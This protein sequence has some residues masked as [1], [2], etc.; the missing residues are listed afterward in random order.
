V[1]SEHLQTIEQL[2]NERILANTPVRTEILTMDQARDRGAMMIFEEKYGDVVRMLSMADSVELCGGTHVRATGDIGL[3]KILT[4]QG[5]A[6]GVRRITA[7]TGMNA[8]GYVREL[9]ATLGQVAQAAKASPGEV[10][11]KVSKLIERQRQLEKQVD[12]L[13]RKW[14][15]GGGT[16]GTDVL[17]GA[18]DI[19]GARVLA[20]RTEV[21]DR[22]A[23]RDLAEQLRDKLGDNAIVL[24]GSIADD[25]AQ[26]VCTVAKAMT[27]RF[28]ASTLVKGASAVVGGTGGGR[29]DLAQ[30]GGPNVERLDD[31]LEGIYAAVTST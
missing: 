26:L 25:K 30:A 11:G 29:P 22:G 28:S 16:G 7:L 3:F 15:T 6:A 23:L 18:R 5:I 14:A 10:V 27:A 21:R 24:V 20:L 2:V 17:L 19:A 8:L 12:E 13:E 9:E 1:S 31:A 4:E